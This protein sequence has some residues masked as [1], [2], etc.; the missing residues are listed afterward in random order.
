MSDETLT[1]IIENEDPI[2]LERSL[3]NLL[4][5]VFYEV[6][7]EREETLEEFFRI[8]QSPSLQP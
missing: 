5:T 8:T 6:E 7:E 1:L 4:S 2:A 3:M